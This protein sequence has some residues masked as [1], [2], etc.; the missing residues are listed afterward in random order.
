LQLTDAPAVITGGLP[1]LA[2]TVA[3]G[4]FVHRLYTLYYGPL[5]GAASTSTGA[6]PAAA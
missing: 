3:A 6:A 5:F 4:L 1:L 2:F